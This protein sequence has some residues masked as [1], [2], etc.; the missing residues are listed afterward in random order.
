MRD[1][2][3]VNLAPTGMVPTRAMTPHVPLTVAEIVEDVTRCAALGVS[4]VHLHARDETGAPTWRKDIYR[5]IIAGIRN[6]HPELILCVSLSGRLWGDFERRA[7]VLDLGGDERP[8]MAS[9]TLGS[10]NFAGSASVNDPEMIGRLAVAMAER[11][12]VPE[13]EVFDTGMAT[14]ASYLAD[15]GVLAGPHYANLLLGNVATAPV[16]PL[17][18]AATVA[19]LPAGTIWAAAGIGRTQTDAAV[20]GIVHGNGVRIGL[21]DNIWLDRERNALATNEQLVKR[22]ADLANLLGRPPAKPAQVRAALGM[23]TW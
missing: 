14:Y 9:L 2:T 8:D 22:V 20:L 16:T 6:R 10:M 1:L 11:G 19:G 13:L 7:E 5:L 15:R 3:L 23:T 17:S 18:L 12:I 4:I 21:E